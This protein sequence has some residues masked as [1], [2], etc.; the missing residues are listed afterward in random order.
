VRTELYLTLSSTVNP[1]W[2]SGHALCRFV[3]EQLKLSQ[4]EVSVRV[5]P[6]QVKGLNNGVAVFKFF[7]KYFDKSRPNAKKGVFSASYVHR[8]NSNW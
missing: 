3:N 5:Q 7:T 2:I 1:T 8:I 6:E 4:L